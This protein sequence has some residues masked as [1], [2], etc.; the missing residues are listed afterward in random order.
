VSPPPL[1][2][3]W[4]PGALSLAVYWLLVLGLTGVLLLLSSALG[5]RRPDTEKDRAYESGIVPTGP[6][7]LHRPVPFYLV[8]MFFLVFDV[9]TAFLVLWAVAYD[10]LGWAG[11]ASIAVFVGVL[12]VG[13]G[14]VWRKG[15]LDWG[16]RQGGRP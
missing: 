1:F 2:S 15:G 9:E 11:L 14:Y 13:L 10:R 8:A 16:I 3:P 5:A 6:A 7:R 12:L 4:E